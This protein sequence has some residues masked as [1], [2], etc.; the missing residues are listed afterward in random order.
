MIHASN[1]FLLY[2]TVKYVVSHERMTELP[3]LIRVEDDIEV[4][5]ET[6]C[7]EALPPHNANQNGLTKDLTQY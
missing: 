7:S 1:Y 3:I 5:I 6:V 4:C 2:N